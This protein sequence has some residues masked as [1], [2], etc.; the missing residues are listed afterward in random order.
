VNFKNIVVCLVV[1]AIGM[2][3][4]YKIQNRAYKH[5]S[6]L[7]TLLQSKSIDGKLVKDLVDSN[8]P[9]L[10][11]FW[12]SWCSTCL[13]EIEEI[14]KLSK[15]KNLTLIT[16]A[17]NSGSDEKI[18]D[19]MKQ[20]GL[21]FIVVNDKGDKLSTLYKVLGYPTT[22]YYSINR[23]KTLLKKAGSLKYKEYLFFTDFVNKY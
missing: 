15:N 2:F 10:V 21:D 3:G 20:K 22:F 11:H 8:K 5:S 6:G 23:N 9:L 14:Q 13:S 18:K 16:V 19:F 1:L 12:G 4:V 17:Q 7:K